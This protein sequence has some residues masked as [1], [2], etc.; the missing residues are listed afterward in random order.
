MSFNKLAI[1]NS[2]LYNFNWAVDCSMRVGYSSW[3]K[4]DIDTSTGV[5]QSLHK[6]QLAA[7]SYVCQ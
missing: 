7:I 2:V 6:A 4:N 1:S 3:S 5:P